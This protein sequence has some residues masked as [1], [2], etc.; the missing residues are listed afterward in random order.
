MSRY[1]HNPPGVMGTHHYGNEP[2]HHH[3]SSHRRPQGSHET[4]IDDID[5]DPRRGSVRRSQQIQTP[6]D[7]HAMRPQD[8]GNEPAYRRQSSYHGPCG[9]KIC[10][11]QTMA[12]T[13]HTAP[14]K[15]E[16]VLLMGTIVVDP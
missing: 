2:I 15:C 4:Q 1:H 5:E 14:T 11:I 7:G 16:L 8:L 9:T 10:G 6:L 12:L 3:Q 13:D